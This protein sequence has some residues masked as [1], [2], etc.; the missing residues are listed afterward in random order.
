MV[1]R[2][3]RRWW[4][5]QIVPVYDALT[6]NRDCRILVGDSGDTPHVM[7]IIFS[8]VMPQH[9]G[10]LEDTPW[11]QMETRQWDFYKF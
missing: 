7:S 8:I 5:F 10:T 4:I 3:T 11:T 1:K 2:P 9:A 6:L